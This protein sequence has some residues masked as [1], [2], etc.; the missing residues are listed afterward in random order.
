MDY[1]SEVF[2]SGNLEYTA[3]KRCLSEVRSVVSVPGNTLLVG[4][5][6]DRD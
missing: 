2:K 5:M 3:W 4:V 1:E 6:E